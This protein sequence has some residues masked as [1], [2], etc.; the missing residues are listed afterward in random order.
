MA[1]P[2][3]TDDNAFNTTPTHLNST[4]MEQVHSSPDPGTVFYVYYYGMFSIIACINIPGNILVIRTVMKTPNLRQP[5]NFYIVSLAVTDLLIGFIYPVYNISHLEHVPEISRPLG[6]WNVCRFLVTEVL[7]LEICSS[8]HLVAITVTRYIA[9]VYPLRYHLYVT[10]RSTK[11]IIFTI[12]VL[13]QGVCIVMYTIYNPEEYIKEPT[14]VCRY[15]LIFSIAHVC[16]LFFIQLF[17]PLLI[18]LGL[19]VKIAR[20]A[21]A[22]AKIIALQERVPWNNSPKA[23]SNVIRHELKSTFMVSILL[24][25]FTI[26]WMPMMIYFFYE[27][28]CV[29][30]YVTPFIRASCRILLF[31]N[32]AVNVFIYAGRLAAFRKSIKSDFT[33]LY[34][35]LCSCAVQGFNMKHS[36]SVSSTKSV[37]THTDISHS[38]WDFSTNL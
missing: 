28:T 13:S 3:V 37:G 31:M 5:C 20:I 2:S 16:V 25:C 18:M 11:F 29:N 38:N 4:V 26:G 17:L 12:W 19:Y 34:K 35:V 9:I 27:I 8:Y 36:N 24:G 7:A 32:S 33:K 30:C 21:R 23:S 14:S 22:Q 6:Q 10:T 1:Q 15:E